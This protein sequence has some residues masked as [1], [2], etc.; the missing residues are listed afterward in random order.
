MLSRKKQALLAAAALALVFG[1]NATMTGASAQG[2]PTQIEKKQDGQNSRQGESRE[3]KSK[4]GAS[5]NLEV[6]SSRDGRSDREMRSN[7]S[8][9]TI[10]TR[11][12]V[13]HDND[14]DRNRIVIRDS[15]RDRDHDSWRGRRSYAAVTFVILGPRHHYRPGWCRGLH[16]GKHWAPG[17]GWHAGRHVGLFRC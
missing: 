10:K 9:E 5:K 16:R 2:Q 6:K 8:R 17:I 4:S 14:K 12:V 15:D 7:R 1:A 3:V 11:T 13:R